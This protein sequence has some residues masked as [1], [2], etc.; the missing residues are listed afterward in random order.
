[1]TDEEFSP[2]ELLDEIRVIAMR[3]LG[4]GPP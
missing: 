2:A 4:A 3:T 1:V